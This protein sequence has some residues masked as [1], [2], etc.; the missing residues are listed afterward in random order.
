MDKHLHAV[1]FDGM[2]FGMEIETNT[3][4]YNNFKKSVKYEKCI[5]IFG[6]EFEC[7]VVPYLMLGAIMR[8]A[9]WLVTER[10]DFNKISIDGF[11][12][13]EEIFVRYSDKP[14]DFR[15]RQAFRSEVKKNE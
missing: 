15:N 9:H 10:M 2:T 6:D 8:E 4:V 3:V 11:K 7:L 12:N 1:N 5:S 14:I 13:S